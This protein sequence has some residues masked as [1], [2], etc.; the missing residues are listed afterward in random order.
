[1]DRL[2]AQSQRKPEFWGSITVGRKSQDTEPLGPKAIDELVSES[3]SFVYG[4]FPSLASAAREMSEK[5]LGGRCRSAMRGKEE[6]P[7]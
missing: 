1:M 4:I 2:L 6:H 3:R 7:R 5:V